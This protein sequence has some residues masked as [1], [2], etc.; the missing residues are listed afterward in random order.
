LNIFCYNGGF[1]LTHPKIA[2]QGPHAREQS[3]EI[4]CQDPRKE[5]RFKACHG[6]KAGRQGG[7]ACRRKAIE[8]S[9]FGQAR[10]QGCR[11][12]LSWQKAGSQAG[13]KK[14]DR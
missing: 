14:A 7:Q 10:S 12:S 5:I 3:P 1:P 9:C 4:D 6:Q 2:T 13:R 8:T 11:K